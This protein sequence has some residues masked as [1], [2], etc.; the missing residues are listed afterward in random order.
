ML[1][2]SSGSR[3]RLRTLSRLFSSLCGIALL[4]V[5]AL[6]APSATAQTVLANAAA[7]Y[8]TSGT[9]TDSFG[10]G[11]WTYFAST[12]ANP[13]AGSLTAL[14]YSAVGNAG[15]SGYGYA[16][17]GGYR[18]PAI[19]NGK[20]FVDGVTPTANVEL[21]WHPGPAS[22]VYTVMRWTAGAGEGGLVQISGYLTR[23]GEPSGDV[24]FRIFVNGVLAH[25]TINLSGSGTSN[26]FSL[27]YT[28]AAGQTVEF[29]LGNGLSNGYGGDE[30]RISATITAV[31]EPA[32]SALLAGAAIIGIVVFRSRRQRRSTDHSTTA[33]PH[34]PT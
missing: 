6:A 14:T 33:R 25:G 31:P 9:M 22:P 16:P 15:N 17:L 30:S 13:G 21:A 29:V 23:T 4:V 7:N 27:N 28:V 34:T 18:V 20:L 32:T 1:F 19:S 11:T 3:A 2:L 12:T 5:V 10:T 24:D 26:T 8:R